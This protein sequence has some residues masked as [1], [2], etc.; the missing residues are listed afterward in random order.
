MHDEDANDYDM[1]KNFN[2]IK[3]LDFLF[4]ENPD[5]FDAKDVDIP[6]GHL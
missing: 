1:I 2:P 4:C 5:D 6:L 3:D